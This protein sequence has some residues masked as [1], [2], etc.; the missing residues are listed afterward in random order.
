MSMITMMSIVSMMALIAVM[1]VTM[2]SSLQ[3]DCFYSKEGCE[4]WS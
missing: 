3:V 4:A 1:S 2:M